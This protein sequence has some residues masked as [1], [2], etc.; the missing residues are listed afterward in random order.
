MQLLVVAGASRGPSA[1]LDSSV[2]SVSRRAVLSS[3]VSGL[4]MGSSLIFFMDSIPGDSWNP[5]TVVVL[6]EV[7]G[8]IELELEIPEG[9]KFFTRA[10]MGS[11]FRLFSSAT[12]SLMLLIVFSAF[13]LPFFT[14]LFVF[15]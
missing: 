3:Q 1:C 14:V 4:A 7:H 2:I 9:S 5:A 10:S 15:A 12:I 11:F 8:A 6:E 13:F